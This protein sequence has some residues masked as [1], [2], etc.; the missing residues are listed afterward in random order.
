MEQ[1]D[2]VVTFL[3]MQAY[4]ISIHA[5]N[6][7]V[8]SSCLSKQKVLEFLQGNHQVIEEYVDN[9]VSLETIQKWLTLK[10]EKQ[11]KYSGNRTRPGI[12]DCQLL[13]TSAK[14][15]FTIKAL[16]YYSYY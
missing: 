10:M 6:T 4:I 16:Y 7:T 15:Q 5:D 9:A 3:C 12:C 11:G 2:L 8:G 14:V 13:S 1:V